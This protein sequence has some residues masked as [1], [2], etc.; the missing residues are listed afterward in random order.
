MPTSDFKLDALLRAVTVPSDLLER[1][2]ALPY[3]DD[4]GLDETVRDVELPQGLLQ[5]LAAIPLAD[6]AGLDEALRNVVVPPDLQ[7]SFH[8]HAHR[9]RAH[10][11]LHPMDRAMR[12]SRIAMAA[13]LVIAVSLSLGS[14]FLL[15]WLINRASENAMQRPVAQS[16]PAEPAAKDRPLETSWRMLAEDEGQRSEV[17]DQ[18]T[19]LRPLALAEIESATDRARR[20]EIASGIMPAGADPLALAPGNEIASHD[21]WDSLP[22]LPWR[23]TSLTPHGLDWPLAPGS[24]RQFLIDKHFHPFVMPRR[25]TVLQS[26]AVPL[27]VEPASYELTRR[28]LER[29]EMPPPDRVRTEDF[30]AAVDYSFPRPSY[31]G[32]GLT[33]AGGASPIGHQSAAI[34][35]EGFSLLQVGVQAWEGDAARHAPLHLVLLVDTSTSMRWGSRLEIVRRALAGL[36]ELLGP[37]DRVSLVTFNQAAHVLVENLGRDAMSQFRAAAES[38]AAEGSTN[39]LDGLR[40]A[41]SAARQ[42]LGP[43]R[44]AVRI[45]LLTDGLL[46][47]DPD[48]DAKVEKDLA[49]AS[50][51]GIRLDAIDLGQ[52]QKGADPQL[53]AISR[54]GQGGVHRA[55]SAEQVRWALREIVTDR[56]QLV[57]RAARLRVTFN[58]RAVLEYRIVGHEAG[59]WA[60]MLP[61]SVEADFHE[62]QAATGLFE[63]R[64]A[65][66]SADKV[67]EVELTWYPADGDRTLGG[68][69]MRRS[70][71]V[72]GR[73]LFTSA[74]TPW[75]FQEAAVAAYTAEV[76]RH[77]PFIFQRNPGVKVTIPAAL[78]RA[79][80]LSQAV[81]R[82]AAETPSYQEL[83]ELIRQ[84]MK[85]RP[86]R[87]ER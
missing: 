32:L 50:R 27:E 69:E 58:P 70:V 64:L 51:Q 3:A 47:L 20:E 11:R 16:K 80:E 45:V 77:S 48:T 2:L 53:A 38:L 37:R 72:A 33:L 42:S 7:S 17:R 60:G 9:M 26:C 41:S 31:R 62:G 75:W 61:G 46:D 73:G 63:L 67:A 43:N 81:D 29:N 86:A 23:P 18:R 19:D 25:G 22:E 28:Y 79:A 21:S 78:R 39:F 85:A 71:A 68:K 12:I 30:L 35:D 74:R 82:Q 87:R 13:S 34:A 55:V 8:R 59:E 44:P 24:N 36:P 49:E 5:R 83:V 66:N 56:S 4:A 84:E 14:A 76:L 57:A 54:A 52:Q 10:R 15:S 65:P 6:D 40:E 1:L